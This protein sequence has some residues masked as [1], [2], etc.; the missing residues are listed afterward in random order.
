MLSCLPPVM[1]QYFLY[2]LTRSADP[3]YL[4]YLLQPVDADALAIHGENN[5][6]LWSTPLLL[7]AAGIACD[8]FEF[9]PVRISPLGEGHVSWTP[10]AASQ[11]HIFHIT[12]CDRASGDSFDTSGSYQA[13]MVSHLRR[14]LGALT[15]Q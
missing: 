14:L 1:Q 6:R 15:G 4:R 5:R 12:H 7:H 2:M 10:D 13:D 11:A 8:S 9:L 3:K